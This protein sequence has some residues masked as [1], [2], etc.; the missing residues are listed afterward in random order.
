[1]G[2]GTQASP[3]ARKV[4]LFPVGMALFAMNGAGAPPAPH[5]TPFLSCFQLA[6]IIKLE[7][8]QTAAEAAFLRYELS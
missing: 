4:F 8:F 5:L 1:M 2:L 3:P 6:G 7:T